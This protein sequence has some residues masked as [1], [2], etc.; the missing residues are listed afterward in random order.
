MSIVVTP[1]A[2]YTTG[3]PVLARH[4][5]A[6]GHELDKDGRLTILEGSTVAAVYN[7]GCWSR[8]VVEGREELQVVPVTALQALNN[9]AHQDGDLGP[10]RGAVDDFLALVADYNGVG[11]ND[12]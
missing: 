6:T 11:V 8:V 1:S 5:E 3:V 12:G 9:A 7:A 2:T 10:L 4:D